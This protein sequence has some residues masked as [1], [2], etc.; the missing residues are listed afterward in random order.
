MRHACIMTCIALVAC[1]AKNDED[2]GTA[3]VDGCVASSAAPATGETFAID[4]GAS[5]AGEG[6]EEGAGPAEGQLADGP[7]DEARG[8]GWLGDGEAGSQESW[9]ALI[10]PVGTWDGLE[11]GTQPDAYSVRV[12]PYLTWVE[13]LSGYQ[14][15]LADG[16]W[17]V[18]LRFR[19]PSY[20]VPGLRV[21]SVSSGGQRLVESLDLAAVAGQDEALS[22]AVR[23][24][25]DAGSLVLDFEAEGGTLPLLAGLE[26]R[27]ATDGP[28]ES[29][30]GVEARGGAGEG[31]LR[32]DLPEE[33]VRGWRVQRSVGGG[34]YEDVT[35]GLL[36]AP[37]FTD[38]ARSPGEVLSYRVAAVSAGCEGSDWAE[39]AAVTV[40]DPAS[41]GIPVV[42]LTVD[43]TEFASLFE[44]PSVPI[45]VPVTVNR[46][47]EEA[48]G[49]VELRGASS[50]RV[51]KRS[52]NIDLDDGTIDGRDHLKLLAEVADPSRIRQLLAYD[53]FDRMG[54]VAPVA[55][56]VLLRINGEVQGV[57]DDIEHV[58]DQFMEDRGYDG[59]ADRFRL[60]TG[61][62]TLVL[63]ED[64]AADLSGYE[65]KENEGDPSPELES[66]LRW[67]DSAPDDVFDTDLDTYVDTASYIGY[68]AGQQVFS[69]YDVADG[70]HYLVLDSA[71]GRFLLVPWD[72]NNDTWSQ[73]GLPLTSHTLYS[74]PTHPQ[75]WDF[76]LLLTRA[77]SAPSF[78]A[79]LAD[80]LETLVTEGVLSETSD[81]ADAFR[82]L[83]GPGLDAEPWMYRRRYDAWL[84]TS[85]E[86][87]KGYLVS[88][89]E[90]IT[91]ALPSFRELGETGLV[92]SGLC[93]GDA[94]T[95]TLAVWGDEATEA[96]ACYLTS[97][98][99]DLDGE[100]VSSLPTAPGDTGTVSTDVP[101]S[102]GGFL[103]LA[104]GRGE[105]GE[106]SG[107]ALRSIV[108]HPAA[109]GNAYVRGEEGW[110]TGGA[111]SEADERQVPL[112]MDRG[113]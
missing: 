110:S 10:F 14:A 27:P 76:D 78:R 92:L 94:S 82:A 77:L 73:A 43:P 54:A 98:F 64:G 63:D 21:F 11:P 7:Y 41:L 56:P 91:T 12:A 80:R 39:S 42:D 113:K 66:L 52:Y 34:A 70:G 65:K 108:F 79:R 105:G 60:T 2:T 48:S 50:R 32:W 86:A 101:D 26:F 13:G 69:N 100:G 29:P 90:S 88:R 53:L 62:F 83:I 107:A 45:T 38:R 15:D 72:L 28:P 104:C 5:E 30:V 106:E 33:Q 61:N 84:E 96:G 51:S 4:V 112:T 1:R 23:A 68:I 103:G 31:L 44:D 16:A 58:G 20:P 74:A 22:F 3:S 95:V 93:I 49:T 57:W 89:Q 67:L 8:Y 87:M 102:T 9:L 18:V 46:D 109:D 97:D 6:E 75:W 37:A 59:H 111:C 25:S 35:D 17:D 24:A 81:R 99:Y 36:P 19:E 55:E 47:G 40:A 85:I 71:T